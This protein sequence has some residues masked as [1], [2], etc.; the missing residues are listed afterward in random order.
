MSFFPRF[1]L[2][3]TKETLT[4][5]IMLSFLIPRIILNDKNHFLLLILQEDTLLQIRWFKD[6]SDGSSFFLCLWY[7]ILQTSLRNKTS[8][9][10]SWGRTLEIQSIRCSFPRMGPRVIVARNADMGLGIPDFAFKW[11]WDALP[12]R[13]NS[14]ISSLISI[15]G[16]N[17]TL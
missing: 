6:T 8:L 2:Y 15:L 14:V 12:L 10:Y 7:V 4:L 1:I 5:F 11:R 17:F 9:S 16:I 3:D 13:S